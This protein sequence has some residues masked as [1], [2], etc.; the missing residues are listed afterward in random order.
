MTV[1]FWAVCGM[2]GFVLLLRDWRKFLIDVLIPGAAVIL[3]WLFFGLTGV[4]VTL[5]VVLLCAPVV[6][7]KRGRHATR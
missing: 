5:A 3:P 7:R 6:N 2:I 1:I 4:L